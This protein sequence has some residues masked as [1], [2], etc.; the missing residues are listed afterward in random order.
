MDFLGLKPECLG[1]IYVKFRNKIIPNRKRV[2]KQLFPLRPCKQ[3]LSSGLKHSH[4]RDVE[5]QQTPLKFLPQ[6]PQ[7]TLRPLHA[8]CACSSLQSHHPWLGF[9]FLLLVVIVTWQSSGSLLALFF[10]CSTQ[11]KELALFILDLLL[12]L[13]A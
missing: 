6:N 4:F 9:R 13:A 3:V 1:F 10:N 8:A 2:D 11:E 7:K 5:L 12:N